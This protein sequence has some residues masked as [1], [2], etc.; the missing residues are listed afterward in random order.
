MSKPANELI[1]EIIEEL[2]EKNQQLRA[3]ARAKHVVEKAAN[4]PHTSI[5]VWLARDG[6]HLSV[7]AHNAFENLRRGLRLPV[8][9]TL[10]DVA[11]LDATQMS[12]LPNCGRKSIRALQESLARAGVVADWC[13]PRRPATEKLE[14][15]RNDLTVLAAA[16]A[17]NANHD[18]HPSTA[19]AWRSA[20]DALDELLESD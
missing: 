6:R 12:K 7:R 4:G 3:E 9:R 11:A 13:A 18:P 2:A 10:G 16:W 17:S 15:L 20:S 5:E 8:C 19:C 14:K 1:G